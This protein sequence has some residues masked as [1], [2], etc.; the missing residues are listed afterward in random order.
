MEG[1]V[2]IARSRLPRSRSEI[3]TDGAQR[4]QGD[5]LTVSF[6]TVLKRARERGCLFVII[7]DDNSAGMLRAAL[8]LPAKVR[9][10][11]RESTVTDS[12]LPQP[13]EKKKVEEQVPAPVVANEAEKKKDEEQVPAPVV[14]NEAEKKKDEGPTPQKEKEEE[15]KIEEPA[16]QEEK[17]KKKHHHHH[18]HEKKEKK[19]EHPTVGGKKLR[20]HLLQGHDERGRFRKIDPAIMPPGWKPNPKESNARKEKKAKKNQHPS[21]GFKSPRHLAPEEERKTVGMKSPRP[22]VPQEPAD[23]E[24]SDPMAVDT[25]SGDEEEEEYYH[26]DI[27][28]ECAGCTNVRC[29]PGVTYGLSYCNHQICPECLRNHVTKCRFCAK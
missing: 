12:I 24:E 15:K 18:H 19:E 3:L 23:D 21:V 8:P 28:F 9:K 11:A 10:F 4:A 22:F 29:A 1:M 20:H 2:T 27:P 17:K 13:A 16:P 6:S 5:D 26:K 7:A 25:S 14:A